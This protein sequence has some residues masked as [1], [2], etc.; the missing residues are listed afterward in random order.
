MSVVYEYRVD[1]TKAIRMFASFKK[2]HKEV[3]RIAMIEAMGL[4]ANTAVTDFM[5]LRDFDTKTGTMGGRKGGKLHINT[6]RLSRSIS[7]GFNLGGQKR[8]VGQKEGI[9]TIMFTGDN[10]TGT[11]GTE[12]PYAAI[13]EHGGTI[14]WKVT[15]KARRFF[16]WQFKRT[17]DEKWLAMAISPKKTFNIKIPARPYLNPALAKSKPGIGVI[18]DRRVKELTRILNSGK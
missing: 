1:D 13:H 10:V 16:W 14:K 12:V 5:E 15:A 3:K 6:N 8:L 4:V 18:F 9:R 17:K 11:L 7:G 2:K